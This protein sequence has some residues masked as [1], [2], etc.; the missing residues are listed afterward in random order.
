MYINCNWGTDCLDRENVD[1]HFPR[2]HKGRKTSI[3]DDSI[4]LLFYAHIIGS[5]FNFSVF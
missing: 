4:I 1:I 3:L 2:S 5:D